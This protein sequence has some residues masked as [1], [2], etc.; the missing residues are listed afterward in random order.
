MHPH[1]FKNDA[2]YKTMILFALI[3]QKNLY[4]TKL[5]VQTNDGG[6]VMSKQNTNE[7]KSKYGNLGFYLVLALCTA[8]IGVSC[9]FAYTQTADNLTIQLDSALESAND[10]A[11]AM[12][13]T[14]IPR[15]EKQP[16][17]Q[18]HGSISSGTKETTVSTAAAAAVNTETKTETTAAPRAEKINA[19]YP[20]VGEVIGAF[21]NGDLVKSAT[22][23]VWQT[24]NGVDIAAAS[25]DEV[26][27]ISAGEVAAVEEDPLW[28]VCVTI[29]HQDGI[30][31]RYCNLDAGLSVNTGDKVECGTVIGVIGESADVESAL[32]AHLHFEIKQGNMYLDPVAFIEGN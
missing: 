27:A 28:G 10:L 4:K 8:M 7:N 25:G 26:R 16:E 6:V 22:T 24:H 3:F 15:V 29:D 13:E 30:S 17:T 19:A 12:P 23:G 18:T 5:P 20:I 14:N 2:A 21:S 1:S 11:A 9:W 32:P 31:S